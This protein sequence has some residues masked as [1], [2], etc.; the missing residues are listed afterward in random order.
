MKSS[1]AEIR[2]RFHAIPAIAFESDGRLTSYAGLVV[3]Q[4]L[5]AELGLRRRLGSKLKH[6]SKG[7]IFSPTALV[8]LLVVHLLLG[9][10]RLR[11]LDYYRDDVLVTRIVGVA[12]L[13]DVATVSRRL[14]GLDER[15]VSG[16]Q[17]VSRDLVLQRLATEGFQ[18]ITLDFD[19][20]VQSTKGHFEGTA[21]GF[22][23]K[24]KGAR[25]YYPLFCTV[26]QTGQFFDMLHRSGNVHDSNGA[27][28]FMVD[29]FEA[30]LARSPQAQLESRVDAAFF[31]DGVLAVMDSYE[32]GF[33]VS[34][35]FRRLSQ[36]KRMVTERQRW[37]RIDDQ[38]AYFERKY[39]PASWT[40]AYRFI[41]LR[42]RRPKQ[43]K[44]PVQLDLFE[45]VDHVYEYK[46][47][48]TNKTESAE[49]VLLFHH[50]RGSQERIFAEGKQHAALDVIMGKR[51]IA[52]RMFTI[53]SMM[54]HNL[55][56]ELQMR[57]G[58]QRDID[59]A[60][61]PAV[62]RFLELGTLRQRL[63]HRA[64]RV[65]RPQGKLTLTINA[66]E[67]ARRD[68]EQLLPDKRQAA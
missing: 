34:V 65:T 68:F 27:L 21:V 28:D 10:R 43:L 24:K 30:V 61:R 57:N 11:G 49:D 50:G 32:V 4:R 40:K 16:V 44:G 58:D 1:K 13:P 60:K 54:A 55:T 62:F 29:C 47:I 64:G 15:A 18:N 22:N 25:S 63:L 31:S 6:L 48:V 23:K 46:V 33:S 45:P 9:F 17:G 42:Q 52:N 7:K 35:P 67:T 36:L 5:F 3:F 8:L 51:R 41:F 20:S 26:A 59:D 12:R 37:R 56:R 2:R 38:W 53:A 19:G 66:N 39:K 14:A